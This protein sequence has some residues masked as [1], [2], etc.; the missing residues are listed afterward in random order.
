MTVLESAYSGL[1]RNLSESSGCALEF[2]SW[3]KCQWCWVLEDYLYDEQIC[4]SSDSQRVLADL[5]WLYKSMLNERSKSIDW[6]VL[7][8]APC[9]SQDPS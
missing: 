1:L 2:S 4:R 9:F 3:G 5:E 6:N 7:R 8:S